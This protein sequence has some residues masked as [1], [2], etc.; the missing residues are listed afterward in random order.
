MGFLQQPYDPFQ[1]TK[2]VS[3]MAACR[4]DIGRAAPL[5]DVRHLPRQNRPEFLF[6]H[7]APGKNA[8]PLDLSW[9]THHN[10]SIHRL[11]AAA[12]EEQRNIEH[13]NAGAASTGGREEIP[14]RLANER[15]QDPLKPTQRRRITEN[16][17][18]ENLAVDPVSRQRARKS[19]RHLGHRVL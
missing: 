15:V 5:F 19:F 6:R 17:V 13:R 2:C 3:A 18:T 7:S 14:A 8:L 9:G 16:K 4:Y 11:L 10:D 1:L 12:F